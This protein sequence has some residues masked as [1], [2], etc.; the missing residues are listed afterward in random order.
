[1]VGRIQPEQQICGALAGDFSLSAHAGRS[2]G[3]LRLGCWGRRTCR[4]LWS[5]R[6]A[7]KPRFSFTRESQHNFPIFH[8]YYELWLTFFQCDSVFH[9]AVFSPS[10][11][12]IPEI[13]LAGYPFRQLSLEIMKC[14]GLALLLLWD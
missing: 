14:F 1:M 7:D 3:T 4:W 5:G 10:L 13:H 2:A 12:L 11:N 6:T 9:C 8:L